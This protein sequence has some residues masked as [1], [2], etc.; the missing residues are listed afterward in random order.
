MQP[1]VRTIFLALSSEN[2]I[3]RTK[4]IFDIIVD[5]PE[6]MGALQDLKVGMNFC[7][8]YKLNILFYTQECLARVDQRADLVQALRHAY[9]VVHRRH[10]SNDSD[11]NF[12]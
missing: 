6:S 9:A 7:G 11:C 5:F 10:C 3:C 1:K 2:F 12:Q 8:R 4:E